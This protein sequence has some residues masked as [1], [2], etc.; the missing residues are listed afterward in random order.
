MQPVIGVVPLVDDQ[1]HSLWMLPGYMQ[2]IEEAGGIP[3]MLP[4]TT[5]KIFL[6]EMMNVCQGILLTGGQDVNPLLYGEE[7]SA[8]C[9]ECSPERDTM[10]AE[11]L[12]IAL[13]EDKSVFG[14]CRG[15]QFLNVYLGG[16]L[17]QDIPA[18]YPTSINHHMTPPYD[19]MIHTV[20]ILPDT[21]LHD[22]LKCSTL[23]VNSYHHQA[24]KTLGTGLKLTAIS[25]DGLT[26]GI[27]MPDHR[28]VLAI[29]WHPELLF[30]K[31]VPS[32]KLFSAFVQSAI[33]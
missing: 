33:K 13:E 14:I 19:R 20:S 5:D 21:P 27:Y 32:K 10:E 18:E 7:V 30:H 16:T 2:G 29:Q 23:P 26:E 3:M 24:V 12:R 17:Y 15:I 22:I 9:G 11:L 1:R 31:D 4:L 8:A 6:E 28:F 25:E